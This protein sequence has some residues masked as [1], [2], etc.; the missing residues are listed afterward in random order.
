MS[1]KSSFSRR[2]LLKMLGAGGTAI[3]IGSGMG[4][5]WAQV[6][7][8]S[9]DIRATLTIFNSGGDNW[10]RIN[11]EPIA[12]FK[13]KYPNVA[14][15][16]NYFPIPG[17]D[18]AQYINQVRTR[19]ASGLPTDLIAM[20]IEGAAFAVRE[21]ILYPIDEFL[22][23]DPEG[24]AI[25]E[26]T[27]PVLHNALVFDGT[28]YFLN[29]GWNDMVIHYNTRLFDEAG[30]PYPS[31]DWT[32]DE[33]LETAQ[34]LT[35]GEGGNKVFGFGL[36][37]ANFELTPWFYTNGT[38]VLTEDLTESNL[39]DPKMLESVQW[40][41]DLVHKHGVSP[42]V[43]G[44]DVFNLFT[45]GRVAMTGAGRWPLDSYV[46]SGFTTVDIQSW[47][48]KVTQTTVFGTAGWAIA[49]ASE[50]KALAWELMK[51]LASLETAIAVAKG[52]TTIPTMEA[53]TQVP[54][55]QEFPAHAE[56]FYDSL[57]SAKPVQ[58][59]PN[60]AE[61][62]NIFMRHMTSIMSN[63]TS[64]ERGLELA[65]RE[66]SEAMARLRD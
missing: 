39:D 56:I 48:K 26:A 8:P 58:S 24:Q 36:S 12:R 25:V 21:N 20:A 31:A 38:S 42:S 59:P 34:A 53:A 10:R 49:R 43:E 47:P 61:V 11:A 60:F 5:T 29:R 33:F 22:A 6:D 23:D 2:E 27:N 35:K 50:N 41:H 65:H 30:L 66:L 9:S 13:Q 51:E 45:A 28:T 40:L 4:R 7:P 18:W 55:Y 17:G 3:A 14:V 19:L 32:W 44:A 62:Q 46:E 37:F 52:Y 63:A 1:G 64:V 16:D 54:E 57:S 15:E